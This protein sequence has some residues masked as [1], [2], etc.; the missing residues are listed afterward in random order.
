MNMEE[1]RTL[2]D[3]GNGVKITMPC[4]KL[5]SAMAQMQAVLDMAKKDSDNPY[6]KSKY[7]DLA[8]CL[9]TAK[10]PMAD[11]GLSIS[12]H[13][14]FDGVFVQCVSVLAHS[15]GQMM[16]STLTI[17]VSKKDAQGIGS[18][19]TYARRYALSA[20]VGIAQKDDDG[21]GSVGITQEEIDKRLEQQ[22]AKEE[23]KS[24]A[25]AENQK[26][27]DELENWRYISADNI[28]VKAKTKDGGYEW[29]N[30]DDLTLKALEFLRDDVRFEGIKQDIEKRIE[31]IKTK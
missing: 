13:C 25:M 5:M 21:N 3:V 17:P 16:V 20:I 30:I 15:S 10:K 4:D 23:A 19:I 11:N 26:R 24:K 7:A 31:L 18:S 1:T 28:E 6:F 8:Q 2:V 22:K 12:Q 27:L 9:Q 29:K 14:T